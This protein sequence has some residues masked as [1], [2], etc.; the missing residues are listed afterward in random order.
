LLYPFFA[1]MPLAFWAMAIA[2]TIIADADI[3]ACAARIYVAT[4]CRRAALGYSPQS[5]LL[6]DSKMK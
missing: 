5:F 1:F 2:A 3:A 4:Q 6:M